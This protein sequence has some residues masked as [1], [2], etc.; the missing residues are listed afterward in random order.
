M[1]QGHNTA[2]EIWSAYPFPWITKGN[3][4][5]KMMGDMSVRVCV[6]AHFYEHRYIC[7]VCVHIW[8]VV[9]VRVLVCG[10]TV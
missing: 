3:N 4:T 5:L 2:L 6:R 1:Q 9:H 7:V 10:H 8:S